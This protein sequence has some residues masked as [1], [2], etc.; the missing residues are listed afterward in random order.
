MAPT[1]T[2]LKVLVLEDYKLVHE[3]FSRLIFP[4]D[5]NKLLVKAQVAKRRK[6][7]NYF[8]RVSLLACKFSYFS[9]IFNY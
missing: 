1:C 6:M 7:I 8:I 5:A 3:V 9:H 2:K 4:V